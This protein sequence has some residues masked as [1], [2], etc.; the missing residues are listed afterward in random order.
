MCI[1]FCQILFLSYLIN[2]LP[3]S[4]VYNPTTKLMC[5]QIKDS[6]KRETFDG[7]KIFDIWLEKINRME[8][9][10]NLGEEN[11]EFSYDIAYLLFPLMESISFNLFNKPLRTYLTKLGL[12]RSEADILVLMFRNGL[13]HNAHQYD[14]IYKNGSITWG[15]TTTAGNTGITPYDSGYKSKDYP[16]DNMPAEKVFELTKIGKNR[17][18][19]SL[20]LDRLAALVRHDLKHRKEENNNRAINFIIG[21]NIPEDIKSYKETK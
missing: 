8:K 19:A 4:L 11:M 21:K 14:L 12:S 9:M 2:P 15:I 6:F 20:Y 17:Y 7:D 3:A 5:I 1:W 10:T 16:Q 13:T 18:L